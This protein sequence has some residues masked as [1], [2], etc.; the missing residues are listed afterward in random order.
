LRP[1]REREENRK[2]RARVQYGSIYAVLSYSAGFV[3]CMVPVP[4]LV[5]VVDTMAKTER[6]D[7]I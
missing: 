5:P 3:K 2:M 1:Q 6:G 4:M 7:E